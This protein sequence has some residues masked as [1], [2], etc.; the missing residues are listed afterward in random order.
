MPI[1][2][3]PLSIM[4]PLFALLARLA[5]TIAWPGRFIAATVS[6]RILSYRDGSS[7]RSRGAQPAQPLRAYVS[8]KFG[9]A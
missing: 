4:S 7:W 1:Q 9:P 5:P 6:H 2:S 3:I 8:M